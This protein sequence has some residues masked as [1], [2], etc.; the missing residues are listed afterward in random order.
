VRLLVVEDEQRLASFLHKGLCAHG[1][2]VKWVQT[3]QDALRRLAHPG[4]SLVILDLGLPDLDG[5]DVLEGL[6]KRG[7]A[8]PVLVLSA[9]GRLDDRVRGLNLGADDYLGKPF[10][11][12]ELLARVRANLRPRT[13][14]PPGALQAGH[15]SIDPLRREA[16]V[17]GRAVSLSAREFSLLKAFA[18]HPGQVLSRQELLSMAWD[19]NFDPQTNLVDVYVGYLRRKLGE[20]TITTIRGAGYRL[21]TSSQAAPNR[22]NNHRQREP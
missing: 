12:E 11:F 22:P 4:I 1:Y 14:A 21:Q 13:T 16:T 17:D 8:V 6:R 15:I 7:S 3:G 2:E 9:R 5:L 19:I 20:P 10:A 18:D